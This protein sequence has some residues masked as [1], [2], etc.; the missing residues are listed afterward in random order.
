MTWRQAWRR[1]TLFWFVVGVVLLGLL[2]PSFH[3]GQGPFTYRLL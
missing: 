3:P 2:L 1:S